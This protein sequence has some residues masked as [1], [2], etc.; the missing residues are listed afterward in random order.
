MLGRTAL[1]IHLL[2]G[3]T[4]A[5]LVAARVVW[6]V[7]GSAHARFADFAFAPPAVLR[8]ARKLRA[9]QAPHYLGHNPLGA[10]MVFA[11]LALLAAVVVTGTV[12]LGGMLKQ[13]PL[14]FAMSFAVGDGLL[15]IHQALAWVVLA[16]IGLHIAG[17]AFES[18]RERENLARAMLTGLKRGDAPDMAAW[19]VRARPWLAGIVVLG[20]TGAGAGAVAALAALPAPG[21]PPATLD[22]DYDGACGSC[23]FAFSPSLAPAAVWGGVMDHLDQHFGVR[24]RLPAAEQSA[25][26]GYLLANSA[27]H[28]DTLAAHVFRLRDPAAPL[29]ITATPYW[30]HVHAGI[31]PAVFASRPV[32]GRLSCNACHAD[33]ASGRFAPQQIALPSGAD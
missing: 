31:A 29:R 26:R 3:A 17:V 2:A 20:M 30:R 7:L 23:H 19:S 27:E 32:S 1:A 21:L 8:Y 10:M 25:L 9:G 33:A 18:W 4:I 12:V 11:L 6:G 28:W 14:A 13:G 5:F 24:V 15:G 22:P 16:L